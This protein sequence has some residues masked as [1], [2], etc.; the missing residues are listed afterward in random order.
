MMISSTSSRFSRSSSRSSYFRSTLIRLYHHHHP[1]CPPQQDIFLDKRVCLQSASVVFVDDCNDRSRGSHN[2]TIINRVCARV[3]QDYGYH[4]IS[5]SDLL[6][7][8]QRELA[9]R[10]K[11][12]SPELAAQMLRQAMLKKS[13]S[14]FE[15]YLPQVASTNLI[16]SQALCQLNRAT[17]QLFPAARRFL[18]QGYCFN[19][20]HINSWIELVNPRT[21]STSILNFGVPMSSVPEDVTASVS[22]S[23]PTQSNSAIA[24]H[25]SISTLEV[26]SKASASFEHVYNQTR[27]ALKS[28]DYCDIDELLQSYNLPG[29]T[30]SSDMALIWNGIRSVLN[31]SGNIRA[32]PSDSISDPKL[33]DMTLS[34]IANMEEMLFI[35]PPPYPYTIDLRDHFDE[36]FLYSNQMFR[37]WRLVRRGPF[38]RCVAT[39]EIR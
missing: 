29:S 26:N 12:L 16:G 9:W 28:L 10:Q 14:L 18:V 3:A 20:Q 2:N 25:K 6:N 36:C 15:H 22:V 1:P 39:G 37:A 33:S 13:E 17:L 23:N 19:S 21:N 30:S 35:P 31:S 7:E 27:F 8:S 34:E 32:M 5:F 11:N 38:W 4:H 24:A